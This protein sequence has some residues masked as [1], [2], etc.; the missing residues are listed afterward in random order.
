VLTALLLIG[1]Y[2]QVSKMPKAPLAPQP[3]CNFVENSRS[4]RISWG[5][6]LPVVMYIDQS[7]PAQYYSAVRAAMDEWN[8][9]IGREVFELG[10]VSQ[11]STGPTRDSRNV[12]YFMKEWEPNK[13]FEQ[14]RTTVYWADEQISEADIR[15][16]IRD[17]AYSNSAV[18]VAGQVD[19]QS[20]MIH[21]MGHVLGLA[22]TTAPG[23]VMV[24]TLPAAQGR[25]PSD[26]L[27]RTVGDYDLR[28]ISCEYAIK[29]A[30]PAIE[31]ERKR[32][33]AVL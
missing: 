31:G 5:S 16:N 2:N 8:Q 6:N 25:L 21:E 29:V 12:I 22:H 13:T 10:G 11:D 18:P 1:I 32:E 33:P 4:Q 9:R 14:A 15:V 20:L 19:F 28:S 3:S 7:V 17:F 23:S 24:K 26:I 30:G 27:R